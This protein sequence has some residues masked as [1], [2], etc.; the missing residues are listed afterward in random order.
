LSLTEEYRSKGAGGK[1]WGIGTI[2]W[3]AEAQGFHFVW[4]DSFALDRGCRI[5]S[6][7]GK[8]IGDDY[9]ATD[10]HEVSGK[11]V[12]EKE[13]WSDFTPNSFSQT[14]YTGDTFDKLKRFLTIKAKRVIK[15]QP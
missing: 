11:Q 9:V 8:W 13:V 10:E 1:S 14:L 6:Q 15:R 3:D 7:L 2:W 5:S 4:C 12:F